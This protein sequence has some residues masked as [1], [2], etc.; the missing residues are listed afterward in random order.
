MIRYNDK[1]NADY[2]F[3]RE[4]ITERID[5]ETKT[6][7]VY[8]GNNI[9]GVIERNNRGKRYTYSV[10]G[11]DFDRKYIAIKY[12]VSNDKAVK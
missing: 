5:V 2:K 10:D 8:R 4:M 6:I 1:Y 9:I 12:I 11:I 7:F 3:K